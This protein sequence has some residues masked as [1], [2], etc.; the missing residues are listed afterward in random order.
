V[1][2]EPRRSHSSCWLCID[3][4]QEAGLSMPVEQLADA[5][6]TMRDGVDSLLSP[7]LIS[8]SAFRSV[9]SG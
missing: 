1:V 3:V 6:P 5:D 2:D 4:I 7:E 8:V 9:P